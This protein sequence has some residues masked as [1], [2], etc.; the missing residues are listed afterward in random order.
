MNLWVF[1][2]LAHWS[3]KPNVQG[4][5]LAQDLWA[6]SLMWGSDPSFLGENLCN[7]NYCLCMVHPGA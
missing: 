6:G 4:L 3:S 2:K 1:R 5:I 7:C